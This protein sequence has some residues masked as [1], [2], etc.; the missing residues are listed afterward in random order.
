[1]RIQITDVTLS[2]LTFQ[3]IDKYI[4]YLMSTISS[5]LTVFSSLPCSFS[6]SF[7]H[8]YNYFFWEPPH[9][10][11]AHT[12]IIVHNVTLQVVDS[13]YEMKMQNVSAK[14][15]MISERL[16]QYQIVYSRFFLLIL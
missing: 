11:T 14:R 9:E 1:M 4:D 7:A 15:N 12:Q 3:D 2:V 8:F 13:I 6:P 10:L 5:F 16:Y